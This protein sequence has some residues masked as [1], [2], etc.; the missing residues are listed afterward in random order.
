MLAVAHTYN[1]DMP[2]RNLEMDERMA[3]WPIE[4][5]VFRLSSGF[6]R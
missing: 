3:Y 5:V 2:A 6:P 4:I 1:V